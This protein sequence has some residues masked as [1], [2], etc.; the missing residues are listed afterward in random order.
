MRYMNVR[1][2]VLRLLALEVML[3][4]R[5][6]G[7][8]HRV[9]ASLSVGAPLGSRT[10]DSSTVNLRVK[11]GSTSHQRD[12]VETHGRVRSPGTLIDG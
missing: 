5:I 12:P 11:E 3:Q 2:R 1:S 9:Q 8:G 7:G 10:G 6:W 4:E